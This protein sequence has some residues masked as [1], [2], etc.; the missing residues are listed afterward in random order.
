LKP[1]EWKFFAGACFLT[2]ALLIPQA[3]LTPVLKGFGLAAIIL[4]LWTWLAQRVNP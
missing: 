2:G 3:G 1:P 4:G